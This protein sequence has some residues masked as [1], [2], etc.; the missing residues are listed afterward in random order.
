MKLRK[1]M[2]QVKGQQAVDGAGVHLVRVLGRDNVQ[3]FDPFLM[4]DSFDSHNP[5]DYEAG[6]PF[7]PHRGIET[8]TYLIKGEIEHEDSLGNKGAIRNGECQW[9]TAGSGIMHEEMPK[10]VG[11]NHMLGFQLWVN[12]P[13]KDKM[14]APK[15]F[16]VNE[17]RIQTVE[18]EHTVV[19]V[20]SGSYKEKNQGIDP[21]YIQVTLLDVQVE[22]DQ[23]FTLDTKPEDNVFLFTMEGTAEMDGQAV[24]AKTAVRFGEGEAISLTAGAEGVRFIYFG[25]KP[26]GE[27]IAW[28][29]PVVMNTEAELQQTFRELN[30][31]TFIKHDVKQ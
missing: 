2:E 22:P 13:Q 7:H 4:L 30:E 14:T 29:G 8:V 23:T 9:M 5:E 20:I 1:I 28:A 18:E 19:K 31:G 17:D 21:D 24:A 27:P 10:A 3:E 26:L 12:L 16:D 25:G 11:D 15:Y 6:F